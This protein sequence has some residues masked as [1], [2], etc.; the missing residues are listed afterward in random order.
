MFKKVNLGW[1]AFAC[2]TKSR[3]NLAFNYRHNQNYAANQE[4]SQTLHL[5]SKAKVD[6]P[7]DRSHFDRVRVPFTKA[8]AGEMARRANAAK[9]ARKAEIAEKLASIGANANEDQMQARVKRQLVKLDDLIDAALDT[10]K[11][12][13]F[14]K[15]AAMK[16]DLWNLVYAKAGVMR[17]RQ[18]SRRG[19][20]AQLPTPVPE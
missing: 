19:G 6:K 2:P 1:Q 11:V 20:P 14:L 18:S 13:Q 9:A 17:P 8:N 15:L 4:S 5:K 10:G 7:G 12:A 3:A 16:K